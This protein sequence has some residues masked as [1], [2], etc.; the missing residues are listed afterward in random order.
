MKIVDAVWEKRNI[1]VDCVE[2]TIESSDTLEN[3]S[4]KLLDINAEYTVIKVPTIKLDF[5][6][7]LQSNGYTMIELMTT[8]YHKGV[9]PELPP[10]YNRMLKAV[11]C[12]VMNEEDKTMLFSKISSGMFDSDRISLD[13][14][15]SENQSNK[16]YIGWITDELER[17]SVLYK[18]IYKNNVCGFFNL[19]D[20]GNGHFHASIGGIYPGFQGAGMGVC[21]NYHEIS[22][23][24]K[25]NAKRIHSA[26]S[27]N[28]R[29][30]YAVHL[31]MS[32]VLNEQFYVFIKHN[33]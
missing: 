32:Y 5:S 1:G 25:S 29:G 23:A 15:F 6:M 9:L 22:E 20:K 8:C 3:C 7:L 18:L 10:I 13:P 28:N 31:L 16:R 4:N 24:I 27:N 19:M 2:V 12:E 26:F 11:S 30:A 33:K 21:M 14:N 17:G